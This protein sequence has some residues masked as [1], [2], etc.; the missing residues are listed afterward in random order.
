M[1]ENLAAALLRGVERDPELEIGL[2]EKYLAEEFIPV[3]DPAEQAAL[4]AASAFA[5]HRITP[6]RWRR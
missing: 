5:P 6:R 1:T 4:I 3:T 2:Y